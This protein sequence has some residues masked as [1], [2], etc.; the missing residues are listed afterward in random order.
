[1]KTIVPFE[2]GDSELREI[3]FSIE[4]LSFLI[5]RPAAKTNFWI[6][7]AQVQFFA[8]ESDAMQNVI[9]S[10][11][12]L[13]KDEVIM[14]IVGSN[15]IQQFITSDSSEMISDRGQNYV[16]IR[17]IAGGGGVCCLPI[18]FNFH[19]L[20]EGIDLPMRVNI[21]VCRC[22]YSC[23]YRIFNAICVYIRVKCRD[24]YLEI[25]DDRFHT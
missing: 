3:V 25:V 4:G 15:L 1:M 11:T 19:K 2:V 20:M 17:P 13:D 10:I 9:E 21:C 16:Y 18:F 22:V 24:D 14:N 6:H 12:A 5:F 7:F 23:N 8:F